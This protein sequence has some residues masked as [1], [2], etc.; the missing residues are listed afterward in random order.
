MVYNKNLKVPGQGRCLTITD[1]WGPGNHWDATKACAKWTP[2]NYNREKYYTDSVTTDRG[3][4]FP[5]NDFSYQHRSSPMLGDKSAALGETCFV[6][7]TITSCNY[8]GEVHI[9]KDLQLQKRRRYCS[10]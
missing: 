8:G 1:D 5:Q 6:S 2:P 9:T 4:E 10:W 3:R 7:I